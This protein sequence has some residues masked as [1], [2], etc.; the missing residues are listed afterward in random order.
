MEPIEIIA[1][2]LSIVGMLCNVLSFQQKAQ[3]RVIAFQLVGA[4]MFTASYLLLGA[5]VG[6]LLNFV[7]IIRAV[8]YM[9]KDKF[10]SE[11]IAWLVG[12]TAVYLL[13]Y[14]LTF[15]A[16]GKDFNLLNGIVEFL[17]II[18][19]VAT[20][21]SFRCKDAASVRKLGL[22][23]VPS[24]FTYNI[25]NFSIGGLICEVFCCCSIVIGMIRLD[26]KKKDVR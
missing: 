5:Y 21:V 18:G 19:M 16:F 22:I 14:V 20:T 8:V 10:R 12:F 26:R 2:V 1:Q 24:W 15:T 9:H 4:T 23:S 3:K 7:A 25:F 11:H 17:P 6:A 13:S